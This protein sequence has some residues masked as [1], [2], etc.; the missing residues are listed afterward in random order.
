MIQL[1]LE[2]EKNQ[3]N[4]LPLPFL[5]QIIRSQDGAVHDFF[6]NYLSTSF[7]AYMK[8]KEEFD[9]RFKGFLEMTASA[10]QMWEKFIPGAELMKDVLTGGTSAQRKKR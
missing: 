4:L 8:T 6:S 2:E 9:R 3:N 10:P 7:E 1:I 5:V